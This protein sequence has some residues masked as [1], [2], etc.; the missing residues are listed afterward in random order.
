MGTEAS[1]ELSR[2]SSI[3]KLMLSRLIGRRTYAMSAVTEPTRTIVERI[4]TETPTVK[5]FV[6]K[7]AEEDRAGFSFRPGQWVDTFIPG[8]DTVGGFSF[9]STP[10]LLE[11]DGVFQLTV[12]LAQH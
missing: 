8:C 12:K 9:A 7:V 5:S 2:G 3:L 11:R 4:V 1:L 10:S 6:L